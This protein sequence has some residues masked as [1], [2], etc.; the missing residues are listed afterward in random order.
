MASLL[1][2]QVFV[3]ETDLTT[4]VPAVSSTDGAIAGQFNWGPVNYPTLIDSEN[5]LVEVFGKPDNNNSD[6]WWSA[7]NFLAYANKLYVTRVVDETNVDT[8]QRAKN[9]VSGNTAFLVRNDKEYASKYNNG[10]LQ[11]TNGTGAWIAKFPGVLGNSL[12]ISVAP[13]AAAYQSTLT[14]TLS[15]TANSLTVTGSGGSAFSTE[16]N[17]GD[18]LVLNS[19]VHKIAAIANSSSLTLADRH[20]AGATAATGVRRWEYYANVDTAPGT[21]ASVAAKGG[22]NDEMH[23]AIVDEDGAWTGQTGT[24]LEVYQFVSKSKDGKINN[25]ATNYY[26]EVINTKSKYVRWAGHESAIPNL[27]AADN[28][29]FGAA[30]KPFKYSLAGGLD[31]ANITEDEK[32]RGYNYYRSAEDIDISFIIGA[33]ANQTIAVHIINN[34]VEV[35]KDCVAFFSPPRSYVVDAEGSEADNCVTFR[36]TLP[37]TSFATLDGNWK[38]QYDVYNDV[39]RYVP[40]NGDTAGLYAQTDNDRDAWW[41]AAGLNRGHIK[42]VINLAWNPRLAERDILYKNG[43]NPVVSFQGEGP[44]LWGNKT[45]QAKPS[46]FDRMNVRRLFIVLEKA[47]SKAAQYTLFEFNDVFTRAQFRNMVEPYLRD[48]QGRRGIYDFLVVCDET[49]NTP[50][51]IDRNEFKGDIY[52]KPA[53]VAEFITLNFVATRTG[54]EF[55]EIVGRT[56]V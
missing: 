48:V 18:L 30:A 17:V 44:V 20:I 51:V 38:N 25:G 9:A 3:K 13:S 36:N 11:S 28:Q 26:K 24:V 39:Y 7:A 42:N 32:V 22:S 23:I 35:R 5:Y 52:I 16:A 12:K 31:G 4:I 47:I 1:S 2:P 6:D 49:N 15:V 56:G 14:G 55:T 40:C 54:V 29:T 53:R 43:I 21:S 8:S 50:E 10:S 34:I 37:S 33:A 27:G 19:E 45:L 41:A 46:A